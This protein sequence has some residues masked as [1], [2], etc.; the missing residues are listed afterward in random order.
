MNKI[1]ITGGSGFLG[2]NLINKLSRS[3]KLKLF[4]L[5]R[6]NSNFDR[7]EPKQI[8]KINVIELD[9]VNLDNIFKK[10]KFDCIIHCAT[11]YGLKKKIFQK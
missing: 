11:N 2:S 7:I 5:S 3:P 9:T 8:K 4:L 10:N 1:L 6:K